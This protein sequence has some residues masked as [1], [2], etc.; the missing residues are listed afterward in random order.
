MRL[1]VRA[2]STRRLCVCVVPQVPRLLH[3][4]QSFVPF[5]ASA[6]VTVPPVTLLDIVSRGMSPVSVTNVMSTPEEGGA[7]GEQPPEA[8][9]STP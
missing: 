2:L 4:S 1:Y 6:T 7:G 3:S 5:V 8:I 9:V